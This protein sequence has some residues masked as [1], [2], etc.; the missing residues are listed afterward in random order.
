MR[1]HALASIV[2]SLFVIAA[3]PVRA[4]EHAA[5]PGQPPSVTLPAE[6]TR[7]LRDYE[8][9]WRIGDAKAVAALFADDGMALPN[10]QPPAPGRAAIASA[11]AGSGGDLRLRALRWATSDSVGFIIGGYRYGPGDG[12]TGKFMLALTRSRGGAWMI[13]ADIDNSNGRPR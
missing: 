3:S 10:G 7:V 4:Q 13:A 1:R 8:K 5:G 6:L 12:D 11:Y 9:G 2:V